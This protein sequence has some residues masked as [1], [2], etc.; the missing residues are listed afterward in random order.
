MR[1]MTDG[2]EGIEH[3][4]TFPAESSGSSTGNY[5]MQQLQRPGTA[6]TA[7]SSGLGTGMDKNEQEHETPEPSMRSHDPINVS[8]EDG[9]KDGA[10]GEQGRPRKRRTLLGKFGERPDDYDEEAASTSTDQAA[11]MPD[12]QKFTVAGQLK[13]TVFNSWI[14]IFILAAPVGSE[15]CG[16]TFFSGMR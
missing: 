10:Q 8:F 4:D 7:E 11:D 1:D 5:P 16:P 2:L 3:A 14:N 9:G 13:A 6:L 12:K 15:Y